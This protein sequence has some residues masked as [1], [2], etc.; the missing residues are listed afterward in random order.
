V[1]AS[2]DVRVRL[3]DFLLLAQDD[4]RL[5][6]KEKPVPFHGHHGSLTPEEMLVPLLM[7][8]LDKLPATPA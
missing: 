4:S 6:V 7:V 3:G 8:R 5:M 2:S 1:Q